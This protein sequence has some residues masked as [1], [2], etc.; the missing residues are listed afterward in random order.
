MARAVARRRR[1][2]AGCRVFSAAERPAADPEDMRRGQNPA[3]GETK[4]QPDVLA[5]DLVSRWEVV[6][7]SPRRCA[8]SNR[9]ASAI[10]PEHRAR[11]GVM[12]GKTPNALREITRHAGP[13][14]GPV[15]PHGKN[16]IYTAS[17]QAVVTT[18]GH[19]R[20]S[21]LGSSPRHPQGC[22]DAPWVTGDRPHD[23][24]ENIAGGD[25]GCPHAVPGRHTPR[26]RSVVRSSARQVRSG[27]PRPRVPGLLSRLECHAAGVCDPA[28]G[29]CSS[30]AQPD[31]SPCNDGNPC[32]RADTC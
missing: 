13:W 23:F 10:C 16:P 15:A 5:L 9:F 18:L 22:G 11:A 6:G 26:A 30:P 31:G 12:R 20:W 1:G 3:A 29:A 8:Q 21:L 19:Y 2:R 4:R 7:H 27:Q 17:T 28:T 32:T 25:R 14:G 24:V